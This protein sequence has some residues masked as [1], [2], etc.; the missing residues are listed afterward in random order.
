MSASLWCGLERRNS[1]SP[2]KILWV[3][4][5]RGVYSSKDVRQSRSRPQR[6]A[7]VQLEL[8][9]FNALSCRMRVSEVTKNNPSLKMRILVDDITALVEEKQKCGGDGEKRC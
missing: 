1:V 8:F 4:S 5:T 7:R 2:K 6:N 9:A 3:L